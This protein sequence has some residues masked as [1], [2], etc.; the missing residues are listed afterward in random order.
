MGALLPF[1]RKTDFAL[2]LALELA[3]A[4]APMFGLSRSRALRKS[5]DSML[6]PEED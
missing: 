4:L 5:T 2:E 1:R 3:R 6:G